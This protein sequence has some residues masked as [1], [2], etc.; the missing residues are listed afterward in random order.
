MTTSPARVTD[1]IVA[2]LLALGQGVVSW[3]VGIV[4]VLV[5][6]DEAGCFDSTREQGCSAVL[7]YLGAACAVGTLTVGVVVT[8][9]LMVRAGAR[10]LPAWPAPLIG[11]VVGLV[12]M[13]STLS[14]LS[15]AA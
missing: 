4:G 2:V 5:A 10:D 12:G 9:V 3:L 15:A 11:T 7:G 1:W 13:V 8:F 14:L 6:S